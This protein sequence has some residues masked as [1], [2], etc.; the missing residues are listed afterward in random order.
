[1]MGGRGGTGLDKHTQPLKLFGSVLLNF[2]SISFVQTVLSN[3]VKSSYYKTWWPWAEGVCF[4]YR[5]WPISEEDV[6]TGWGAPRSLQDGKSS[7]YRKHSM[8]AQASQEASV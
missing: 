3:T 5:S 8:A 4:L 6:C 2:L 1:M 7:D